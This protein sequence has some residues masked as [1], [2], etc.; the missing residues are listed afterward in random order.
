MLGNG[1]AWLLGN[2]L[3]WL[4]G[5]GLDVGLGLLRVAQWRI[6]VPDRRR[7]AGSR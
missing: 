6:L 5:N 2:G 4:L 7:V 1:L 3:A